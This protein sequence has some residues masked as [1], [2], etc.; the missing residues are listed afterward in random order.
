MEKIALYRGITVNEN[1]VDQVVN[2][3]KKN[4]LYYPVKGSQWG[5]FPWKDLRE[6]SAQLFE[7]QD[8]S[9]N[10]TQP[11]SVWVEKTKKEGY[12]K[13][14]EC[15]TGMCFADKLGAN[16]YAFTHNVTE[17]DTIPIVIKVEGIDIN[18]TA[19]DGRDF[20]Y[21]V[22]NFIDRN[23]IEKTKRQKAEL[24]KVYGEQIG[25]YVDKI[26]KHHNS[27]KYAVC[28]LAITDNNIIEFHLKNN[29]LI[30]GRYNTNFKSAFLIKTPIDSLS[31]T[32]ILINEPY[33]E[34]Q[35]EFICLDGIL[36][37]S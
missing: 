15:N 32:E 36:E 29:I 17:V 21:T 25:L 8:L 12:R 18:D 3:I 23:D 30:K 31:I 14:T 24:S 27:D 35:K 22:F 1:I 9:R 20:L 34:E 16:Y 5:G 4:G 19:I 11:N 28:D 7:K 10:D 26:M 33:N 37:S 6:C 2:D 13:Y